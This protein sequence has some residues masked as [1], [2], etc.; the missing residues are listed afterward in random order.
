MTL[1]D[2]KELD[3]LIAL[4]RKR[5]ISTIKLGEMELTLSEEAPKPTSRKP[6]NLSTE[7]PITSAPYNSDSP[8]EEELL[9]WSAG[10][11]IPNGE[12]AGN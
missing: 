11:G 5:G 8:T 2:L 7:L 6:R 10:T 9:Y 1:P 12:P 4:C 3:K